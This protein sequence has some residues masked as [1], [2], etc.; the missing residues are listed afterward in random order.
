MYLYCGRIS[1][2][3]NQKGKKENCFLIF[4]LYYLNIS[5]DDDQIFIVTQNYVAFCSHLNY[6]IMSAKCK[7]EVYLMNEKWHVF[8]IE[9]NVIVYTF[10][11]ENK[12]SF[13]I[14]ICR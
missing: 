1:I 12:D 13:M 10:C 6:G 11:Y 14:H 9:F 2:L 8:A 3:K 7:N 4:S 5:F